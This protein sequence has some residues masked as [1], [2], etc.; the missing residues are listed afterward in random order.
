MHEPSRSFLGNCGVVAVSAAVA[1]GLCGGCL[2]LGILGQGALDM[3]KAKEREALVGAAKQAVAE[4]FQGNVKIVSASL[5]RPAE[6]GF[7]VAGKYQTPGG[8]QRDFL[9]TVVPTDGGCRVTD[10][11]VDGK[12][13]LPKP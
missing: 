12:V 6:S 4:H 2:F 10:L 1:V 7:L 9:A 3:T 8:R 13:V 11:I 5:D